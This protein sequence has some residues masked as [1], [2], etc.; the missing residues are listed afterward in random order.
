[1]SHTVTRTI[2]SAEV[3]ILTDGAVTFTADLFPET[4]KAHLDALLAGTG[5]ESIETNFNATLIRTAGRVILID[6]GPRDL[7]GPSC[8]HLPQALTELGVA[9]GDIDTLIATHLHP[10][11]IAGMITPDGTAVFP[12]A[13]LHVTEAER[14][15]W[16][17]DSQFQGALS[18]IADWAGLAQSVLAAYRDRLEILSPTQDPA[19]GLSII[20]LAG[21]TP[22]HVGWRLE[23]DGESLIHVG[24][25]VHAQALQ[26]ADPEV[27]ISFD[28]DMATA[29]A[30]RKRLL[31]QLAS[32]GTLFTGGHFLQPAFNRLHRAGGG[33]ALETAL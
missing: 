24:D 30:T 22:G 19:P 21:H 25:I 7:F 28:L 29:R 13:T 23:R 11:H 8:G 3:S 14:R 2:G 27:G 17:D 20:P 33:F 18:G 5:A 31:D 32:D 15:F 12:K 1:M 4:V 16:T 10:D 26:L 9:A 6:A